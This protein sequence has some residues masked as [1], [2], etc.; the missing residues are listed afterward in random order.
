V[1]AFTLPSSICW[2]GR[3]VTGGYSDGLILDVLTKR[4]WCFVGE[5][6]KRKQEGRGGEGRRGEI[7]ASL[8]GKLFLGFPEDR[9]GEPTGCV[10]TGVLSDIWAQPS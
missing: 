10:T 8:A 1:N 7:P 2:Y 3:G 5:R 4:H 9:K 6:E